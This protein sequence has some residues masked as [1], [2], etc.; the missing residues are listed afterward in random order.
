MPSNVYAYG[1]ASE[2]YVFD[3]KFGNYGTADGEF[4]LSAVVAYDHNNNRIIVTDSDIANVVIKVFSPNCLLILY[5]DINKS[6]GIIDLGKSVTA[7]TT[8]KN[9]M[10]LML[11]SDG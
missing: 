7:K 5:E 10:M 1:V 2:E 6:D 11:N 4:D 3:F 8:T 9:N